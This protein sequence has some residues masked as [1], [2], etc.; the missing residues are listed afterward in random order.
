MKT[1]KASIQG[2]TRPYGLPVQQNLCMLGIIWDF[3]DKLW[4][5][6]ILLV[7]IPWKCGKRFSFYINF[8]KIWLH[9]KSAILGYKI[10]IFIPPKLVLL[11]LTNK[12]VMLFLKSSYKNRVI[13]HTL[14]EKIKWI[15]Q[16]IGISWKLQKMSV[17]K[18]YQKSPI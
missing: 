7:Q 16:A 10:A 11:E 9:G 5:F 6:N 12:C 3:H 18:K 14:I 17:L 2:A 15:C 8:S 1:F 4:S 13:L